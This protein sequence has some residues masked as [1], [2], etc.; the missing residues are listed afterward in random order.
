[1]ASL[2]VAMIT[3]FITSVVVSRERIADRTLIAA[4]ALIAIPAALFGAKGNEMMPRDAFAIAFAILLAAIAIYI[5]LQPKAGEARSRVRHVWQRSIVTRDGRNFTYSVPVLRSIWAQISVAFIGGFAGIGG[6]SIGVPSMT[7]IMRIPHAVA[8]PSMHVLIAIQATV[9]V[10]FHLFSG[11]AGEPMQDVPWLGVGVLL[12]NP[13]GQ[14]LRRSLGEGPLM[15][16]L[17][18]GLFIVALRT[19]WGAF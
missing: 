17:A 16:A 8:V 4:I 18:A 11:N 6:G 13:F 2:T 7:R 9:V 19:A 1:M 15:R 5:V 12:A 10:L 14:R 3:A